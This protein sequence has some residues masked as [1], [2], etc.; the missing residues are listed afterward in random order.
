MI[1]SITFIALSLISISTFAMPH[2]EEALKAEIGFTKCE[3]LNQVSY[4][5]RL[6]TINEYG[7]KHY[8]KNGNGVYLAEPHEGVAPEKAT[9]T[10]DI[11]GDGWEIIVACHTPTNEYTPFQSI[12]HDQVSKPCPNKSDKGEISVYRD[13]TLW[14]DKVKTDFTLDEVNLCE[15]GQ[16]QSDDTYEDTNDYDETVDAS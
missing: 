7:V 6:F 2:N 15:L 11:A 12:E 5:R 16:A 10:P 4:K 1:K 8:I 9:A 3:D 14:N 13:Y